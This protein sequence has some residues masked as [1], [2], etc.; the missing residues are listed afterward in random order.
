MKILNRPAGFMLYRRLG[1]DFFSISEL[2][3]PYTKYRLRLIRARHIFH[4]TSD[5]LNVSFGTVDLSLYTRRID[6][7]DDYQKKTN[8]YACIHSCGVQL[9]GYFHTDFNIPA[10]QNQLIPDNIFNKAP[11]RRIAIVTN[12]NSAF[13]R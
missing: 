6:L 12:S 9:Y 1:V 11:A 8:R 3:Y 7:K 2:L 5:N 13:T 4:M 10:K